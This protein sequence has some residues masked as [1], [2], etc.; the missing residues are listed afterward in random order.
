MLGQNDQL[1]LSC[2]KSSATGWPFSVQQGVLDSQPGL[3]LD[4]RV[5]LLATIGTSRPGSLIHKTIHDTGNG[6]IICLFLMPVN[7]VT[8]RGGLNQVRN[9][10]IIKSTWFNC[11]RVSGD[12][13]AQGMDYRL[14]D[15]LD[16]LWPRDPWEGISISIGRSWTIDNVTFLYSSH[17]SF[18]TLFIHHT[19][20]SLIMLFIH[21]SYYSSIHHTIHSFIHHTVNSFTILF[22]HS[23]YN[24]FIHHTIH[25]IIILFIHSLIHS[26]IHSLTHSLTHSVNIRYI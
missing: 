4:K 19:I 8:N 5:K 22:I 14:R 23:S 16:I 1:E 9:Y 21:S 13:L 12:I 7:H 6:R 20:H 17:Y 3:L 2:R 11:T 10:S 25:S 15:L 18:N 26:P 24:S